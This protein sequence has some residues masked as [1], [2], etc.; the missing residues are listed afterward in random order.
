MKIKK[1]KM[2]MKTIDIFQRSIPYHNCFNITS[3]GCTDI[4]Q[5]PYINTLRQPYVTWFYFKMN[6]NYSL[7][8]IR[9]FKACHKEVKL[10]RQRP[11][12]LNLLKWRGS[13][14]IMHMHILISWCIVKSV[15]YEICYRRR[16]NYWK[17][18][19]T[20]NIVTFL[21]L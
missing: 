11:V 4:Y 3:H 12:Y 1:K 6:I 5:Q 18:I 19:S 21:Y 2:N 8:L 10:C 7:Q 20:M 17:T 14:V 13:C 9:K 16:H 15:L